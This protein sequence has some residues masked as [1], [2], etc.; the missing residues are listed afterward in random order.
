MKISHIPED[1]K[2]YKGLIKL[3]L[4]YGNNDVVKERGDT[5]ELLEANDMSHSSA[6]K[7][8]ELPD[9]LEKLGPTYIKLGQFLSTRSDMI[10]PQYIEALTRLQDNV[11]SFAFEQVQEIVTKELGVR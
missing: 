4:K 10:A 2:R 6:K 9:D 7:A 11:G 8:S 1:L 3:F 5:S